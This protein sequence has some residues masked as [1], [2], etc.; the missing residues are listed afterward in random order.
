MVQQSKMEGGERNMNSGQAR[1]QE[2]MNLK[3]RRNPDTNQAALASS[4]SEV[5]RRE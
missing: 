5:Q 1:R 2:R 4:S 3:G